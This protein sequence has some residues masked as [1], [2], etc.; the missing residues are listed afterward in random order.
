MR[1][2]YSAIACLILFW[3]FSAIDA[4]AGDVWT[5]R[6]CIDY[7]RQHNIQVQKSQLSAAS[8]QV[9]ILQSKAA[10]FPSLSGS[11]TQQFSNAQQQNSNG[12]YKYEGTFAGQYALNAS[13]T[14][15]NGGRNKN[16]IKQAY[17]NKSAQDLA[18][19]E[20]QNTIELSITEAYL[21]I[22]YYRESIKNNDNL[23]ATSEAELKQAKTFLDAGSTTRSEYAQVEAQYSSAKYNLVIAQ[24]S[25]DNYKL[26]LRQLLE[27]D[28]DVDF[29]LAFP[30]IGTEQVMQAIAS[31]EDIYRTALS[32]M[33]QVENSKMG[34]DIAKLARQSAK[35]GYLPT[36]A[37]VGSVGSGNV[38]DHSS[39]FLTQLNRN[40]N[41]SIGL[42]VSI[43]IFDN[44]QNKS[45]T[46]KAELDVKTAELE[47]L[48][49]QKALLKTIEGLYQDVVSAQSKYQAAQDKVKS[50]QLSYELVQEQYKLG[51]RNTVELTTE[52]N[53]YSNALQELLQAKYTAL[54][55]LKLLNFYQGEPISL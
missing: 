33:P 27:L 14:I 40:F 41:Q 13:V 47:L 3:V 17:M 6:N 11:M 23:V 19:Q 24:N 10:L 28:P 15:Y 7:A 30:E 44:R 29:E 18:T 49:T 2:I 8:Y 54:L 50:T 16:T 42:T 31:K 48:D 25:Y 46:Q 26:Q 51:V 35:A 36:V 1:K 9:D 53:N 12:D 45:T 32:I 4:S 34:I 37:I 21:Q 5:L 22:L 20:Q 43:P 55:S 39:S 38:Y 52:K